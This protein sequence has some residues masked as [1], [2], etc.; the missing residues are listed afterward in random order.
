MK[1]IVN[2][3]AGTSLKE[4]V[5]NQLNESMKDLK[6]KYPDLDFEW[7]NLKIK[8]IDPTDMDT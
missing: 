5:I 6:E 8:T 2:P 1:I 3:S 7:S 4:E